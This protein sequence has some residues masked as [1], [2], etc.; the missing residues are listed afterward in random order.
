MGISSDEY[1]KEFTK[2]V[3][4]VLTRRV[5]TESLKDNEAY[6]KDIIEKWFFA[7]EY[8]HINHEIMKKSKITKVAT[9]EKDNS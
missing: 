3:L 1:Q 2:K 7:N 6:M 8:K 4:A 5:D 9:N